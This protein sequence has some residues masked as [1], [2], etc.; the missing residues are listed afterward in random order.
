[1]IR[2]TR[3]AELDP[4][5][6]R[7]AIREVLDREAGPERT[8][9][10]M[11][12]PTGHDAKLWELLSGLG[13]T[14]LAIPEELGGAGATLVELGVVMQE[15]GRGLVPCAF[16][17]SVVLFGG[18]L[19]MAG[20]PDQRSRM[21]PRIAAGDLLAS[22]AL[23][24]RAGRCE[25]GSLGLEIVDRGAEISLRG[26]AEYV[27]DADVAELILVAAR[28]RDGGV[29]LVIL[30]AGLESLEIT[31]QPLFDPT[32]RFSRLELRDV[33]VPR[34]AMLGDPSRGAKLREKLID[35]GA[36]ALAC[37]SAGGA[38]Q[39][40][41]STVAYTKQRQQFDRPVASF[42]ALKHRCVDMM[43]R[44]EG[45]AVSVERALEAFASEQDETRIA[46]SEAKFFAAD[47][48]AH[49]ARE[50]VQMHGGVGFT[51]EYDC[52]LYLKRALLN[53]ALL[54]DSRW[55]RDRAAD[56]LLSPPGRS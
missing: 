5:E 15:L 8:R 44:V 11:D 17:P 25:A 19:L 37:D 46:A 7:E 28:S 42:Q 4:Q 54:G 39:V 31:P 26:T 56:A 47:G 23:V 9:Q 48:Y 40:L 41:E 22:A 34:E 35:L 33:V 12:Q 1:M 21:L 20:R 43:M 32:R 51:W 6:L 2:R 18:A 10:A 14:G 29:A 30:D 52:H 45:S 24:G 16:V 50:G 13:W 3:T 49:V 53:Q 55:H 38:G 36:I 27:P